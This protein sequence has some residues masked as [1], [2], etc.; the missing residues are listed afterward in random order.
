[1]ITHKQEFLL[2]LCMYEYTR[3]CIH[4]FNSSVSVVIIHLQNYS[5]TLPCAMSLLWQTKLCNSLSIYNC[6]K[7][8]VESTEQ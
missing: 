1:M 4:L 7:E 6:G 2:C 3:L 5:K 8:M